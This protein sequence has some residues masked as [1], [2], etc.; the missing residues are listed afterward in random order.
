M[1]GLTHWAAE[2]ALMDRSICMQTLIEP[3]PKQLRSRQ[4]NRRRAIT[5]RQFALDPPLPEIS[6]RKTYGVI[7]EKLAVADT[8]SSEI[9]PHL[10]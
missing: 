9:Y 1:Q 5:L 2:A 7:S 6:H 8:I 3:Y 4:T 10:E